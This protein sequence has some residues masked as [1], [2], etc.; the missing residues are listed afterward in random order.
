MVE[1]SKLC[2]D[3]AVSSA[4]RNWVGVVLAKEPEKSAG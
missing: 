3:G 2:K 1:G 4:D